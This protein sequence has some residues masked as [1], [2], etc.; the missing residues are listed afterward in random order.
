M[1]FAVFCD[2]TQYGK[3]TYLKT[4]LSDHFR[5]FAVSPCIFILRLFSLSSGLD[6]VKLL[7]ICFFQ[8]LVYNL[9]ISPADN[10]TALAT[11]IGKAVSAGLVLFTAM[12]KDQ[13]VKS[14]KSRMTDSKGFRKNR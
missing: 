1:N 7:S 14:G 2:G 8:I 10:F 4:A 11:T 3:G 5:L 13:E 12:Q 6:I 9:I